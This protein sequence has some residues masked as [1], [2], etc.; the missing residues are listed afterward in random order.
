M[1]QIQTRPKTETND[2]S[3]AG[4]FA[5]QKV[6]HGDHNRFA[7]YAVHTRFDGLAWFTTDAE[8]IDPYTNEPAIILQTACFEGALD[9]INPQPADAPMDPALIAYARA[10]RNATYN[11]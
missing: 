7:T 1:N 9:C 11:Q 4:Q 8:R 10:L 5:S 6:L 2:P 3:R